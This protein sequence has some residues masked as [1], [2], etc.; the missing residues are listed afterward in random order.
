MAERS[1]IVFIYL[2]GETIAVPAGV[3]YHDGDAGVGRFVYGRKYV[4]RPNAMPADPVALP[5]GREPREVMTNEG[6]YGAF[7]DAAPGYWGRLVIASGMNGFGAWFL[8]SLC[9][10]PMITPRI[11]AFCVTGTRWN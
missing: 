4:E 8:T 1:L 6:F 11:M 10:I 7:V 5:L 2:P 9:E 3:F